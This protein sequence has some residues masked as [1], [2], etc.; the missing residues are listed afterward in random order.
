MLEN[1]AFLLT[2]R[3]KNLPI[4]NIVSGGRG[5]LARC[6]NLFVRD[7]SYRVGWKRNSSLAEVNAGGQLT[8]INANIKDQIKC[9]AGWKHESLC[10]IN[11]TK[12]SEY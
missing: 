8:I 3:E 10:F 6:P 5:E 9:K 4:I 2:K 7:C 11:Y 12:W 1:I